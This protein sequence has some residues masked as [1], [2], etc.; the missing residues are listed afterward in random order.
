MQRD[1]PRNS[2]AE[3]HRSWTERVST[4][5][6]N[7]PFHSACQPRT[8]CTLK[9]QS[10]TSRLHTSQPYLRVHVV[11]IFAGHARGCDV[12]QLTAQIKL[13]GG[14]HFSW[15]CVLVDRQHQL[16]A[17]QAGNTDNGL[18]NTDCQLKWSEPRWT[19]L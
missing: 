5:G 11:N 19:Q 18:K 12:R 6:Y 16:A 13:Q 8:P 3:M 7:I 2:Y 9:T 17:L 4:S 14:H 15:V 10:T 1:R